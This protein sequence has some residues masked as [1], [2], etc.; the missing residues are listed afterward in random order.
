MK[1]LK[2]LAVIVLSAVGLALL[3]AAF[4][5]STYHVERSIIVNASPLQCYE[6]V[7]NLEHYRN[8]NPWSKME[9]TAKQLVHSPSRGV[10]AKWSWNG[11]KIGEGSLTITKE[12]PGQ[13]LET[14]LEF[15][16]PMESVSV[17]K[18]RFIAQEQ[19]TEIIWGNSGELDYPL[20]R[21]FGLTI[22]DMLGKDFEKGLSNLK[23]YIE[24]GIATA[25][26]ATV[27]IQQA[28]LPDSIAKNS[29]L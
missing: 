19:G 1:F 9:P 5:P 3:V 10:G 21:F 27:P 11:E 13:G 12:Q 28:E 20:G 14:K 16:R 8:W 7:V 22:N 2:Y 26:P 17:G 15:L 29:A 24:E 18:W 25:K 4:L 23:Q 6:N